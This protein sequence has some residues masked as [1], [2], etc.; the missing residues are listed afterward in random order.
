[1]VRGS[2]ADSVWGDQIKRDDA[3]EDPP[4]KPARWP[5]KQLKW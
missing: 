4:D 5:H 2:A 1:M 3:N